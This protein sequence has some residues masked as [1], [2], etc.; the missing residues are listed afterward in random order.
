MIGLFDLWDGLR[1]ILYSSVA[2]YVIAYYIDGSL[3]PW[4]AFFFL[5]GHMSIN[6]IERQFFVNDPSRVD[7]TG[8]QMVLLMKLSGFAWNVHDGRL[9][10][11][12]MTDSQRD[13]AVYEM[14]GFLDYAGYCLFFPSFFIGPA[15]DYVD[16]SRYLDTTMF[17]YPPPNQPPN[18]PA[19]LPTKKKRRI[20]RSGTPAAIKAATGLAWLLVYLKL[21][22][23]YNATMVLSPTYM[24]NSLPHRIWLL[25]ILGITTRTKY[26]AVWTLT[27]GSCILSGLGYNGVSPTTGRIQWD[28]LNNVYPWGIESAQNSRAYLGNWNKNTNNW[29]RN[30]VYLRVT[31]KGKKPGFR[32]SLATFVTS[33]FWHG[34]APGYY[35]T[36][37]LAAFIQTVAK[38]FRRHVRPFFLS[39]DGKTPT[40]NK[41]YYDIACWFVTQTGFC[42]TTAPFVIL[43]FSDS[44]TVWAR[45]YFYCVIG[46]AASIALFASPAKAM[47]I[48]RLDRRNHP[49][50]RK[51]LAEEARHEPTL[52]VMD[53][54][55]REVEEAIEEIKNEVE[56]RRSKGS[57]VSMPRGQDL[58]RAV[59]ERVGGKV[60]GSLKGVVEGVSQGGGMHQQVTVG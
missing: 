28:K 48:K 25:Y 54:P 55:G 4:V 2:T 36:F 43:G 46:V 29:L 58:R 37:V 44:L 8:A 20:P 24:T 11:K 41:R 19:K 45:V 27:E 31:P 21:N 38:N 35:L 56:M 52:G 6:H 50:V 39:P 53:D 26:Y 32:A 14:P 5:M 16:Y 23:W 49:H 60:P 15:F 18:A 33:A 10:P 51:R 9:D 57:V 17:D 1:T 59:E 47:L 7:I 3:M 42:F 22:G 12:L 30:Y 40:S 13:R 34:F